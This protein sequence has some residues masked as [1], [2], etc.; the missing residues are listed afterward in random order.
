MNAAPLSLPPFEGSIAAQFPDTSLADVEQ[1]YQTFNMVRRALAPSLLTSFSM[2]CALQLCNQVK[3]SW[4]TACSN[5]QCIWLWTTDRG[6]GWLLT[7]RS[8]AVLS[9]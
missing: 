5:A 8:T 6:S 4:R 7:L 2:L 1:V 9:T 3:Q